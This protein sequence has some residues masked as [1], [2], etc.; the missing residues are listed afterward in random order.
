MPVLAVAGIILLAIVLGLFLTLDLSSQLRPGSAN[1]AEAQVAK[2][3]QNVK[4]F[5]GSSQESLTPMALKQGAELRP[6]IMAT[7]AGVAPGSVRL[8]REES[9]RCCVAGSLLTDSDFAFADSKAVARRDLS[10]A[11]RVYYNG[12]E[13]C[14]GA[15]V[16]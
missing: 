3:I 16:A 7:T 5:P 6:D 13:Y 12:L 9:D 14:V 8:C 11:F 10:A 15:K 2:L 4:L 1:P